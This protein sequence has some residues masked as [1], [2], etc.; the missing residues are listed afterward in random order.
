MSFVDDMNVI[1]VF[2]QQICTGCRERTPLSRFPHR[3]VHFGAG[4]GDGIVLDL[5]SPKLWLWLWF[6]AVRIRVKFLFFVALNTVYE[7]RIALYKCFQNTVCIQRNSVHRFYDVISCENVSLNHIH[8][9]TQPTKGSSN[10]FTMLSMSV[11]FH[12]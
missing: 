8:F 5:F 9:L 3:A 11:N 10:I 1:H 7:R 12:K 4:V 2:I 6:E